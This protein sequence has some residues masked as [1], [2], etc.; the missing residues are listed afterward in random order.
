MKLQSIKKEKTSTGVYLEK[1]LLA[2][3]NTIAENSKMSTN[4][5]IVQLIKLGLDAAQ[6]K[7]ACK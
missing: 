1:D 5:T 3:L 4:E 7:E 2:Q 6:A